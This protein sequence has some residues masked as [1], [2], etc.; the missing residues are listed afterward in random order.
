MTHDAVAS[1]ESSILF[2]SKALLARANRGRG[3]T[4]CFVVFD[5]MVDDHSLERT[6][7][8][9]RFL[10]TY[11]YDAI[12]ILSA[13]ND[14][15]QDPSLPAV[16]DTVK[17]L[18]RGY[19][20]V[21]TYG[22]SMGGYA[23][24]RFADAVGAQA[25]IAISPQY[26]MLPSVTPFEVRWGEE[27]DAITW[28]HERPGDR[29]PPVGEAVV[30]Y[31]DR[32]LDG[33]HAEIIRRDLPHLL[34]VALPHAGHPAGTLLAD[35]GVMARAILDAAHGR[36]DTM[37]LKASLRR[38]QRRSGQYLL[39][40]ARRQPVWR[41]RLKAR[42]AR[43]A[44]ELAPDEAAVLSYAGLAHECA[45]DNERAAALHAAATRLPGPGYAWIRQGRSLWRVGR[46]GEARAAIAT[47]RSK[48]P[49]NEV[50]HE[51]SARMALVDGACDD[52]F[53]A[54]A[55]IA[56]TPGKAHRSMLA[57]AVGGLSRGPWLRNGFLRALARRVAG[58]ELRRTVLA[59]ENL[60]VELAE[61]DQN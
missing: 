37:A 55:S 2:R 59:P 41:L 4:L 8:A 38:H 5:P 52:G 13:R 61:A 48:L 36:L 24:L 42:L 35:A 3:S 29:L 31:D 39:T 10:A 51:V 21:V 34:A 15:Y 50:L 46:T 1:G 44:V 7:F 33:R 18:T 16:L 14:W 30:F 26:S 54:L 6:A 9:E 43:R 23:A 17:E 49:R 28:L 57:R 58:A 40:L 60:L 19:E 45:G 11:G 20:R 22:S 53:A 56:T 25:A 47:A 27:R 32:W 12:H